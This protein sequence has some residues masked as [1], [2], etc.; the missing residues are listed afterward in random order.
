MECRPPTRTACFDKTESKK[1][2]TASVFHEIS[3]DDHL[4]GVMMPKLRVN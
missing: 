2:L 3:L 4:K 1:T